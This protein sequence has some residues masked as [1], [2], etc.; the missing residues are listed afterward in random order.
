[1][2]NDSS[3][4]IQSSPNLPAKR[5]KPELITLDNGKQ[6]ISSGRWNDDCVAEYILANAQEDWIPIAD[7]AR[8]IGG[9]N[10]RNKKHVRGHMSGLFNK[11]QDQ[12]WILLVEYNDDNGA[13]S[14]VKIF[15]PRSASQLERQ[16]ALAKIHKM[17]KVGITKVDRAERAAMLIL[18]SNQQAAE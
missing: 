7:L 14:A 8:L 5:S 17:R 18:G 6:I 9:V 15:D 2:L 12:G 3:K 11:L 13:A 4:D 10:I 1:M 16:I